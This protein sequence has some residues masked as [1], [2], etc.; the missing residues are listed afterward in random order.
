MYSDLPVGAPRTN[1]LDLPCVGACIHVVL[2]EVNVNTAFVYLKAVACRF[3]FFVLVA[4]IEGMA[5][6]AFHGLL[7]GL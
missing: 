1:S 4:D 6:K 2:C 7:E 3:G 5:T